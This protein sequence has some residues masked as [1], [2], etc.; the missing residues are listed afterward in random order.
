MEC[1]PREKNQASKH[2]CCKTCLKHKYLNLM[3][4]RLDITYESVPAS[5]WSLSGAPFFVWLPS[6]SLAVPLV[7]RCWPRPSQTCSWCPQCFLRSC[8]WL[9]RIKCT[10]R[11]TLLPHRLGSLSVQTATHTILCH[12]YSCYK[13]SSSCVLLKAH[14]LFGRNSEKVDQRW[15]ILEICAF[16]QDKTT[17]PSRL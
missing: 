9:W 1:L 12:Q 5:C 17:H 7:R 16:S 3:K 13:F 14:V 6:W 10:W 2:H 8:L 4:G 11:S 15:Y